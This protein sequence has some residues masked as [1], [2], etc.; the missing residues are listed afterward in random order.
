MSNRI[1]RQDGTVLGLVQR[2]APLAQ[3]TKEPNVQSR[4]VELDR[5][6]VAGDLS[7]RRVAYG[8]AEDRAG[9]AR[10]D[11]DRRRRHRCNLGPRSHGSA[12]QSNHRRQIV[13]G[14]YPGT[15]DVLL[16]MERGEIQGAAVGSWS[17]IKTTRANL[18]REKKI[19]IILAGWA[20]QGA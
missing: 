20:D 17:E 1:Y 16:A 2:G 9:S 6:R 15:A 10:Q 18:L 5:Q 7:G 3:L 13:I 4:E 11:I 19:N 8:A 14:E 12:P